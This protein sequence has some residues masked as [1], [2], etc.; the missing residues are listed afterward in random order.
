[1][2]FTGKERDAETG[3][4]YFGA[5]Y[6]A[7]AQGRFTTPDPKGHSMR[8]MANPQKW[9]KYSYVLNNPLALVDPDGLEEVTI[10]YRTFIP[11]A[12]VTVFGKTNGGDNRGFSTAANASHR[13]SIS[14]RIETDPS[15]RPGNPI[16]SVAPHAGPSTTIENGRV[17]GTK[18]ATVG[19]P[20]ATGSRDAN[21]TPIINIQQN[22]KN[23]ESPVPGV[24][25][26]GIT[27]NLNVMVYQDASVTRVS[28]TAAQFPASELNV[29]RA[30]GTT[31]GVIQY[32]P[33]PGAT[34]FSLIRP[35]RSV[36][37]TKQTPCK[38]GDPGCTQ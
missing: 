34:P 20:T 23:P 21:G 32:M 10:T 11:A 27:A 28:G 29:T 3:L 15:I 30:D 33:P 25:T 6:M 16:I 4:D 14:V 12:S 13:T 8:T 24:L 31:T 35:D 2:H 5:R 26:P 36:N 19:L 9:N 18:T 38:S 37:E 1:M 22:T 17:V 7:S